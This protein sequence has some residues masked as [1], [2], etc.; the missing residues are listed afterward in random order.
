M[1]VL[2][3]FNTFPE[4]V[5]RHAT[6]ESTDTSRKSRID[7]VILAY[8]VWFL[9]PRCLSVLPETAEAKTLLNTRLLSLS[10]AAAICG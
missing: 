2:R 5:M 1:A 8:Q 4:T 6:P 10:S 7:L 3:F 9:S